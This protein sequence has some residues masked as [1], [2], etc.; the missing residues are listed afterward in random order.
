MFNT[1]P[2]NERQNHNG[3]FVLKPRM[4]METSESEKL[5]YTNGGRSAI[6]TFSLIEI[7]FAS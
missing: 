6:K 1:N 7:Q 4:K 5:R 3:K 2:R